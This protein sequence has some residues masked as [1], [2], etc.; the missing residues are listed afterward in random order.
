MRGHGPWVAA[1]AGALSVA[2]AGAP[3]PVDVPSPTPIATDPPAVPLPITTAAPIPTRVIH[4]DSGPPA[5]HLDCELP[6]RSEPV[7]AAAVAFTATASSTLSP[8]DRYGAGNAVD[9]RPD[10]A[11]VE[12]AD[13]SGVGEK[14]TLVPTA[15]RSPPRGIAITWGYAKSPATWDENNRARTVRFTAFHV[16]DPDAVP[17]M[18][19][20]LAVDA[21]APPLAP[22]FFDLWC[23]CTQ[24]MACDEGFDRFEIEILGVDGGSKYDDTAISEVAVY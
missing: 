3:P 22:V 10:T 15:P 17:S 8:A 6:D 24:N 9:G 2:C 12:G 19:W 18:S 13:G 4:G 5:A 11:W 21:D 1:I 20:D 23:E 16:A 7:V 14:L